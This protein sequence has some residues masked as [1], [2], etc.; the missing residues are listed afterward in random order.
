MAEHCFRKAGVG[1]SNP[2]VGSK[3]WLDLISLRITG[4]P[5]PPEATNMAKRRYSRLGRVEDQKN[6]R[7]AFI[8]IVGTIAAI[9][10]I[11]FFGLPVVARFAAFL[12]EINQSSEPVDVSDTIPPVPPRFEPLPEA[13]SEFNIEIKG[14]TE[15]GVT[16]II[17]VNRK[18]EEILANKDGEFTYSFA[19][20]DGNNTI[21]AIARDSSGNES[22][23]SQ[24]HEIE[25]DNDPPSLNITNPEDGSEFF[26]SKQRQTLIE[27]QTEDNV[28]LNINDRL[29]V[30]ESDG[31][32]AFATTLNEGENQFTLKAEDTAGNKSETSIM[33][34]FTP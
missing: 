18:E 13:T 12:T 30:V 9:L 2:P 33:L 14:S 5:K 1:G 16:V 34:H 29:V 31:S 3:P 10:L 22:Q 7:R 32:F 23:K 20:L 26:G 27:G 6:K 15:P 21:S 11:F 28:T 8:F 24:V 19:L 17:S 25:Y 4:L